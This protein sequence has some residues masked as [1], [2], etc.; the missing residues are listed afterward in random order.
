[1][2]AADVVSTKSAEDGSA[3]RKWIIYLAERTAQGS[4]EGGFL[5]ISG[6]RVSEKETQALE[7]LRAALGVAAG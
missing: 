5:G 6:V 2:R 3:F 7:Q 4:K 1:V